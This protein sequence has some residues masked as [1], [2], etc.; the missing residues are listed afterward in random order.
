MS[1]ERCSADD[2]ADDI[3][4]VSGQMRKALDEVE[5]MPE[6]HTP[7]T[8][9]FA[10]AIERALRKDRGVRADERAR[11][12]AAVR[13]AVCANYDESEEDAQLFEDYLLEYHL[14]ALKP[15]GRST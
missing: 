4:H 10:S 14:T 11:V 2:P 6:V 3:F 12:L 5:S 9:T 7:L 8:R 15:E 1:G 13:S